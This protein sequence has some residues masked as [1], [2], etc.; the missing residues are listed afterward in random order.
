MQASIEIKDTTMKNTSFRGG[1]QRS[2][3][4]GPS[5]ARLILMKQV[6][7]YIW[8]ITITTTVVMA[9]FNFTARLRLW[10][11]MRTVDTCK[12]TDVGLGLSGTVTVVWGRAVAHTCVE[13]TLWLT[14]WHLCCRPQWTAY[15]FCHRSTF[16]VLIVSLCVSDLLS[17]LV[18]PLAL[19]RRTWGFDEWYLPRTLRKVC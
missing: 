9:R 10:L 1:L 5:V 13:K 18:S 4:M 19:H 2:Y 11:D 12:R 3:Q 7:L 17:A 14:C 15:Y 8:K 6:Q 16:N